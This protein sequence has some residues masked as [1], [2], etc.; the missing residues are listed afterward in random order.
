MHA[1]E[2]GW[3][4][5]SVNAWLWVFSNQDTTIYAIRSGLGARGHGVPEEILGPDFDGRLI[6]DGFG[7]PTPCSTYKKGQCNAHLIRR[8]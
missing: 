1:D 2:T 4:I 5:N 8:G 7:P 6:V 3:R